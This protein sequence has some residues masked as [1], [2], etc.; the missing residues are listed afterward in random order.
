MEQ[1]A[2][3][4]LITHL[5]N[6]QGFVITSNPNW[7]STW[8][9]RGLFEY[10]KNIDSYCNGKHP[11]YDLALFDNAT[12]KTPVNGR[13]LP[14]T[15]WNTFGNTLILGFI[16][17]ETGKAFQIIFGHLKYNPLT[18]LKVG[19][20][21]KKGAVVAR[22]GATNTHNVAMASHLHFQ[23]QPYQYYDE[24]NFTCIGLE[25]T[26]ISVAKTKPT[27]GKTPTA[28]KPA[29]APSGNTPA[30]FNKRKGRKTR[31]TAY[32]KGIIRNADGLGAAQYR[33]SGG[34]FTNRFWPDIGEGEEVWIY[35]T[36]ASGWGKVYSPNHKGWVYLDRVQITQV[37]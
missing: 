16:E 13:V 17:G 15:G 28:S 29:S 25:A 8:A 27:T 14:G 4:N 26:N 24:W 22:Q 5:T 33:W 20:T 18:Y 32:A 21:F 2:K 35:A 36:S 31:A 12:I 9:E 1:M 19:Q 3:N 11:A 7:F 10:G 34:N 30:T 23:V 37:F 6:Q